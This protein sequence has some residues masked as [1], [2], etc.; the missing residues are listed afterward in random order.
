[1]DKNIVITMENEQKH[2]E[3]KQQALNMLVFG[4]GLVLGQSSLA[5][6]ALLHLVAF[7]LE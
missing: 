2:V 1:M 4:V 3:I 7:Y 6:H 5:G